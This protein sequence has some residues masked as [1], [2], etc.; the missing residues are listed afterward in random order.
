MKLWILTHLKWKT[1]HSWFNSLLSTT[2][3]EITLG[4]KNRTIINSCHSPRNLEDTNGANYHL[5]H[6]RKCLGGMRVGFASDTYQWLELLIII[7]LTVVCCHL[8]HA[9]QCARGFT[10]AASSHSPNSRHC[11]LL[12]GEWTE[13]QRGWVVCLRSHSCLSSTSRVR[14]QNWLNQPVGSSSV[15]SLDSLLPCDHWSCHLTHWFFNEEKPN[16]DHW[17]FFQRWFGHC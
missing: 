5:C 14:I 6:W 8:L 1:I 13:A 12:T 11:F 4:S 15:G 2:H 9:R 10:Y 3:Q 17:K 7:W 16:F